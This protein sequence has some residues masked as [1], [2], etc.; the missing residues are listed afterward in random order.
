[1]DIRKHLQ[2][3]TESLAKRPVTVDKLKMSSDSSDDENELGPS[4]DSGLQMSPCTEVSTCMS[5]RTQLS[6]HQLV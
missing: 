1:M 4:G 6:L 5:N 2:K 3:S